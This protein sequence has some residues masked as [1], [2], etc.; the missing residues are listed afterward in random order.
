M[1][2]ARDGYYTRKLGD[3]IGATITGVTIAE[4]EGEEN[5]YGIRVQMPDKRR[6]DVLFLSDEEGNAPG[7]M[8]ISRVRN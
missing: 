7:S 1:G 3:L 2:K 6:F 5:F 8:E 4:C